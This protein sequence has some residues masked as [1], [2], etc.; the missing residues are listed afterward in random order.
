MS[1]FAAN[2]FFS[3]LS[4]VAGAYLGW[5]AADPDRIPSWIALRKREWTGTWWCVWQ[6]PDEGARFIID[7]VRFTKGLGTLKFVVT[8]AGD[9]FEWEGRGSIKAPYFVGDFR[10]R[11]PRSTVRGTFTFEIM[12]QGDKMVG[13]FTGPSTKGGLVTNAGLFTCDQDLV[14]RLRSAQTGDSR[15]DVFARALFPTLP[16]RQPNGD[17][18]P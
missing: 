5:L 8:K 10:S 12:P 4:A 14:N 18:Q 7:E 9:Q 2:V 1:S 3:L 17:K 6:H 13:Y 11:K 16:V 15:A